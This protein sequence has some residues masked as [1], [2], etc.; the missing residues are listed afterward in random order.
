MINEVIKVEKE[1]GLHA[2]PAAE[3]VKMANGF[4]SD[5]T[6][7]YNGEE[8]DG[9]SIMSIMGLG[10]SNGDSIEL[11]IDGEDKDAAVKAIAHFLSEK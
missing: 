11:K 7:V 1:H 6:L 10:I 8:V 3:F 9:K 5:I 4:S 2:R